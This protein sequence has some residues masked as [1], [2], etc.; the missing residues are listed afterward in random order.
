MTSFAF[1]VS[2]VVIVGLYVFLSYCLAR[3]GKKLNDSKTWKAWVPIV[4]VFYTIKLAGKSYWW[5]LLFLIPIVGIVFTA[6]VWMEIAEKTRNPK[7]WGILMLIPLVNIFALGYLAFSGKGQGN[8]VNKNV[9]QELLNYVKQQLG[10]GVAEEDVKK[11]LMDAGWQEENI[12]NA[13][14][15]ATRP[16]ET[17]ATTQDDIS[18]VSGWNTKKKIIVLVII[19]LLVG[20]SIGAYRHFS[21]KKGGSV[22]IF[23]TPT[24]NQLTPQPTQTAISQLGPGDVYIAY[25]TEFDKAKN[26]D[27]LRA[28][29]LKYSTKEGVAEIENTPTSQR[30]A[31]FRLLKFMMADTGTINDIKITNQEIG[32]NTATLSL[33]TTKSPEVKG[34]V[35]LILED[36]SWKID[37]ES[38]KTTYR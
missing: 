25:R 2:L 31:G 14:K 7:W 28:L 33:E 12:N 9:N 10:N 16:I 34:T 1:I 22:V 24:K 36:G 38:W 37:L 15:A 3:I 26:F 35:S 6:I 11:I 29:A 4:N 5:F 17:P 32:V 18:R 21:K 19:C 13:I 20:G 23:P 27:D 8:I 30:E